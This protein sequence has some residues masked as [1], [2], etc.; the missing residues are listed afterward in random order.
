MCGIVGF[1]YKSLTENYAKDKIFKMLHILQHRGPDSFKVIASK[2][3]CS[4]TARLAIERIKTGHQP[5]IDDD[6]KFIISFNGEIFN[7]K[8]LINK[9]FYNDKN[10]NSEVQ[11]LLKIFLKKGV[12]FI[13]EIQGQFSISIYDINNEKLY[14]FRD[15]YG[16]RPLFYNKS[17]DFFIYSSEIKAISIL[18]KEN[19]KT[20]SLSLANTSMFWT[21][22]N[23]QT[24]FEDINQVPPGHYLIFYKDKIELTKYWENPLC[25]YN[26]KDE[27]DIFLNKNYFFNLLKNTVKR[28]I[29]GEVGFASYISGG[30]DSSALAYL[31]TDIQKSPINTF[32]VEFKNKDYDESIYQKEIQKFIKS[33]HFSIKID[34]N[35]I[36]KNFEKVI[37]HAETHLFRT[38]PVPMYLLSKLVKENGHKVIFTGE[39]AD[40]ILLGYDIFGENKIRKFWAKDILSDKRPELLKRLYNYLPQF[41]EKKYFPVI[42]DFFKKNLQSDDTYFYSHLIRW[43]QFNTLKNFFNFNELKINETNLHNEFKDSLPKNFNEISY[44]RKAQIL[45]I[46]TLLSGYLLSSQGDRMTMAHGVE[47]RYP[48]LDDEFTDQIAKLSSNKKMI[49]LKLKNILR[50]SFLNILPKKI[51]ERKKIAYQA[52]EGK[53]FFNK[54]KNSAIIDDFLDN[55]P[56]NKK[57]NTRAFQNLIIKFKDE[58]SSERIGFRENMALII[59]LSDH[60]LQKHAKNWLLSSN[61]KKINISYEKI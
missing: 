55:L 32:S 18:K 50:D 34:N 5:I 39:G 30:I 57:L 35:D 45:E 60:C 53:S 6:K 28:Q 56:K 29:H 3:F 15:R 37:W 36:N 42:K 16:I 23:T 11:L 33:K 48:Y 54:N 61:K 41:K 51:S 58:N 4:A 12:N 40:E 44:N 20:S 21:N 47:G 14:L 38:A 24:A 59:G 25:V 46:N 27:E 52:P 22:H 13:K 2:K 7:Y 26:V 49:N 10:I 31:L 9:Y 1:K 43:G 19:L 17:Q 8:I